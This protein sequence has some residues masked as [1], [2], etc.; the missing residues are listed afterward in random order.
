MRSE[1]QKKADA[2]YLAKKF[3]VNYATEK[4]AEEMIKFLKEKFPN[5]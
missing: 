4:D 2:K 3:V 1:A 5:I